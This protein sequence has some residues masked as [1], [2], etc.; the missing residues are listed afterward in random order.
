MEEGLVKATPDK[1]KAK[2]ILK[3][4]DTTIDMIKLIDITKF[5]SNITKEY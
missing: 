4:V 1:E 5:S 2:P 3:M